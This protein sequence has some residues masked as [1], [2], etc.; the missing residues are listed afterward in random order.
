MVLLLASMPIL[1]I[2]VDVFGLVPQ[3]TTS[4]VVIALTAVLA[5]FMVFAPHRIDMIVGFVLGLAFLK[6]PR[7]GAHPDRKSVV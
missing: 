7:G 1:G 3:S 6:A 5:T 2:S 4:V